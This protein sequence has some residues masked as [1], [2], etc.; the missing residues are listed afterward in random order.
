VTGSLDLARTIAAEASALAES[1]PMTT[2]ADQSFYRLLAG[3]LALQAGDT[4]TSLEEYRAAVE[5][6]P[7]SPAALAGLGRAQAETGNMAG[8]IASYER[9]VAMRPEP[10]TLSAL[11]DLLSLAGRK[12]DAEVRHDQVRGIAAIQ[13]E[14]GLV[15]RAIV[16]FLADHGESAD[17][18]VTLAAA[19]LEVRADV[20]GWDA[21]AWALFAAG[22][23]AEA[24]AAMI[25]A[26]A[27]GT[28]DAL[29]DYHA[30]MIAAALG[31]DGA[32]A[33]L[34]WAAL[35]RNPAFDAIGAARARATMAR[36]QARP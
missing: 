14:A 29:L 6:W 32:A 19:E 23:F 25:R 30:G 26:R 13:G 1:N 7:D 10:A 12:A 33:D 20:Y 5:T 22:R 4:T 17:W 35:D 2:A 28:E 18:A 3:A 31:R 16:Q 11:G 24:D 8:A 34:L 36:L 15:S 27:H 9:A 21:Y